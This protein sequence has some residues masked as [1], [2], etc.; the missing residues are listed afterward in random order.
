MTISSYLTKVHEISFTSICFICHVLMI[1]WSGKNIRWMFLK[2][3]RNTCI[4]YCCYTSDNLTI[5]KYQI[6]VQ[7]IANDIMFLCVDEL[8][9]I[10]KSMSKKYHI[11]V[12]GFIV[13]VLTISRPFQGIVSMSVTCYVHVCGLVGVAFMLSWAFENII[14]VMGFNSNDTA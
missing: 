3:Y 9:I 1:C 2:Y 6:I 12:C 13:D 14:S 10:L 8:L 5:S 11:P 4:S 7:N